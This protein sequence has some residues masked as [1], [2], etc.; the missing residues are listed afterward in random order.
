MRK[1]KIPFASFEVMHTEIR[2]ELEQ[3][4][5]QVLGSNNFIRGEQCRLFEE[6]FA[7]YCDANFCIGVGN[8]LDALTLILRAMEIG[9]GDEVIEYIYR[10]SASGFLCRSCACFCGT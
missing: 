3:A 6:E 1:Q 2:D 8:G 5:Q 10:N 4:Y 9:E 7:A